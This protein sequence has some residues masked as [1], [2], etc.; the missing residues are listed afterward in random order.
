MLTREIKTKRIKIEKIDN[1]KPNIKPFYRIIVSLSLFL[2]LKITKID[3]T[4]VYALCILELL[5][6]IVA[7][8][9]KKKKKKRKIVLHQS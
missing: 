3:I 4:P 7:H 6:Q 2:E 5:L 8:N 9:Q 1:L